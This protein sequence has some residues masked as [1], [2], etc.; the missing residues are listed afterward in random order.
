MQTDTEIRFLVSA[1]E[2]QTIAIQDL[3]NQIAALVNMNQQILE[4]IIT[5][6]GDGQ[7][8]RDMDGNPI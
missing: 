3:S 6:D 1:L 5:S 4:A 2:Q 8:M 7:P